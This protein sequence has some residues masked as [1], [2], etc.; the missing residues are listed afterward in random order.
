MNGFA[1]KDFVDN[2]LIVS[3]LSLN[4]GHSGSPVLLKE[5]LEDFAIGVV[6]SAGWMTSLNG[7]Q[8]WLESAIV[9]NDVYIKERN[10]QISSSKKTVHEGSEGEFKI[11]TNLAKGS[12]TPYTIHGLDS[13]DMEDS[14]VEGF[15]SSNQ[16]GEGILKIKILADEITEGNEI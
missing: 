6:S 7:H 10:I 16:N 8:D 14:N 9:S 11:Q 12:E 1:K 13:A 2:I 4:S 15:I 3:G 5:S